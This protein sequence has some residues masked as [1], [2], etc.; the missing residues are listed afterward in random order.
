[1]SGRKQ[2][3]GPTCILSGCTSAFFEQLLPLDAQVPWLAEKEYA[4][5]TGHV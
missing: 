2:V 5:L 3:L 4:R 1:M